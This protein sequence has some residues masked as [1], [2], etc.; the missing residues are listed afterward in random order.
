MGKI[1]DDNQKLTQL[2]TEGKQIRDF[3]NNHVGFSFIHP[4][5]WQT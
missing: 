3:G 4:C 2:S 5:D 1:Q